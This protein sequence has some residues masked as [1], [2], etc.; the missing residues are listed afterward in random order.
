M[1]RCWSFLGGEPRR[2]P[3][4]RVGRR[5]SS[6]RMATRWE[7]KADDDDD[8]YD[9]DDED[10]NDNLDNDRNNSSMAH[11]RDKDSCNYISKNQR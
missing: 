8:E 4:A 10:D 3:W 2:F 7:D 9:K 1:A 5:G 6:C 11:A